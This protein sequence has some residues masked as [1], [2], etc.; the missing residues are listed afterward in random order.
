MIFGLFES[1]EAKFWR[2]ETNRTLNDARQR[3]DKSE[4]KKISINVLTRI[5]K[6][7]DDIKD[8]SSSEKK[9]TMFELI[10]EV[11][12]KRRNNINELEYDNTKWVEDSMVE[13][14]LN[15]YCGYFGKKLAREAVM[16]IY[17][18]RTNLSENEIDKIIKKTNLSKDRI[19]G[20]LL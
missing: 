20:D 16:V 11:A 3:F 18:C 19:F 15:M 12:K 10:E 1:K 7:L 6:I 14:Y 2:E 5:L 9:K 13:S 17:W 8:L 4:R